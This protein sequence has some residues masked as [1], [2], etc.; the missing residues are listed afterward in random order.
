MGKRGAAD[1]AA[2]LERV[3]TKVS[4]DGRN[5]RRKCGKIDASGELSCGCGKELTGSGPTRFFGHILGCKDPQG[6][7]GSGV[8]PKIDTFPAGDLALMQ[9][10]RQDL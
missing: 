10:I 6:N 7:R 4:T 1:E 2:L 8:C 9:N 3:T 5:V